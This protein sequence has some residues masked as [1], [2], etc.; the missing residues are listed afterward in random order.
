M[1]HAEVPEPIDI[2]AIG[3]ACRPLL[4]CYEAICDGTESEATLLQLDAAVRRI[5]ALPP[6]PGRVGRAI[7]TLATGGRDD[8]PTATILALECLRSMPALRPTLAE[9]EPAKERQLQLFE[10]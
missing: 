9:T 8:G 10:A 5:K 7:R 6:L 2:A 4:A 3:D 1:N